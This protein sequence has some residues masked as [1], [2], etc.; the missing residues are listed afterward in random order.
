MRSL[1]YRLLLSL[2][3]AVPTSVAITLT[4]K[5]SMAVAMLIGLACGGVSA[6]ISIWTLR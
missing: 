4:V 1:I 6:C 2:L 5:P 3:I